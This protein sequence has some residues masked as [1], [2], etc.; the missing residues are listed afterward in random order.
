MKVVNPLEELSEEELRARLEGSALP[1]HVAIIMD[2]NGRWARSRGF[3]RI[4]GHQAGVKAVR[5]VVT[6]CREIGVPYLTLYAFSSENWERPSLEVAALMR[7]LKNYVVGERDE[8][9]EKEI[10]L[11]AI[12][13][14]DRLPVDVRAELA[15]TMDRTAAF[16][17]LT[18]TL[19]L[20]YGGRAELVDAV[21][22]IVV[23]GEER[24]DESVISAH[25]YAP[26]HPD[27]DLLVRT[28]GE[29]RVSNFLLWEI[30]YAEMYVTNVY[31]P[32]FRAKHLYAAIVDYIDRER[33]FGRV[34]ARA[35]GRG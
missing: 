20:S 3:A 1:R 13:R 30:A 27:P 2:G 5:E 22:R 29:F 35:G 23:S 11:R 14:L 32:D 7:L 10:R 18:L 15:R 25:L 26:D 12:G 21:R 16:D 6:A 31:W 19:A 17:R 8:L 4:R 24:V 33:R 34:S 28:S 9:I